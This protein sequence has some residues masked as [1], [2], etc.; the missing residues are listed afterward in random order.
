MTSWNLYI[1]LF[2]LKVKI[3]KFGMNQIVGDFEFKAKKFKC[4]AGGM[5]YDT[6]RQKELGWGDC[7]QGHELLAIVLC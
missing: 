5:E 7:M 6:I 2:R 3:G 1:N 4:S